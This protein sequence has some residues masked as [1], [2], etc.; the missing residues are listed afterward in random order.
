MD[1]L[2]LGEP[3]EGAPHEVDVSAPDRLG[4]FLCIDA[5]T[6]TLV[7]WLNG[8]TL[9]TAFTGLTGTVCPAL[10]L[11]GKALV[12]ANFGASAF[13]YTPPTGYIGWIG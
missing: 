7:F 13:K 4:Y 8:G 1:L 10:S 6:G 11:A 3:V 9:G 2:A 12:V 5:A